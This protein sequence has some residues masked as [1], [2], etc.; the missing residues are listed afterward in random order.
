[1]TM[2]TQLAA[3]ERQSGSEGAPKVSPGWSVDLF[4]TFWANPSAS[5]DRIPAVVAPDIVGHWPRT[6][7]PVRG[8]QDYWRYIVELL[9]L[10]PDF[11]LRVIEHASKAEV[12][13]VL[14]EANGTGPD[15]PFSC[16]GC[17]CVRVREGIVL[18]NHICCAHPV[19][20]ML[21]TRVAGIVRS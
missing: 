2:T 9:Q 4:A 21:A 13:F 16:T 17:D 3:H 14:W 12:H 1:M 6:H 5:Q 8:A 18:E 10:V 19:F 15:G 11:R 20:Q 7:Q